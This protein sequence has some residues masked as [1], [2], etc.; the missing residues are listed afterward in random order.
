MERLNDHR[1]V[2]NQCAR[3]HGNV[4]VFDFCYDWMMARL[5]KVCTFFSS[6]FYP[7]LY[8]FQFPFIPFNTIFEI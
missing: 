1:H 7:F 3:A 4:H 2:H 8:K 6:V 5:S